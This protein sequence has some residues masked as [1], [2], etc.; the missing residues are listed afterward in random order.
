MKVKYEIPAIEQS[1]I[2]VKDGI[3][4]KDRCHDIHPESPQTVLID[5]EAIDGIITIMGKSSDGIEM[6]YIIGKK[7]QLEDYEMSVK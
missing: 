2:V 5:L 4:I 6:N 7:K 1:C 3:I